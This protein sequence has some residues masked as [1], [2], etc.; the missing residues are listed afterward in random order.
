MGIP[1]VGPATSYAPYPSSLSLSAELKFFYRKIRVGHD[2]DL[3]FI[4]ILISKR[5][6]KCTILTYKSE[7]HILNRHVKRIS[8]HKL[9]N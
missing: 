2:A 7:F 1:L 4:L 3:L 5:Q 6:S 9:P 8:I